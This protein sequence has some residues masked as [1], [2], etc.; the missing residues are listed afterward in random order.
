VGLVVSQWNTARG[1]PY[2]VMQFRVTLQDSSRGDDSG[3]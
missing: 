1:W 2:Q 3:A